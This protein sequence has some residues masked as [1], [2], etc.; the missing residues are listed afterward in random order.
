[1]K[2]KILPITA[3]AVISVLAGAPRDA[4]AHCQVPCGIYHDDVRFKLIAEHIDTI[5]KATLQIVELSK[6][7]AANQNQ[8]ARWVANKESHATKIQRIV[9]D[10]FVAQRVKLPASPG[11]KTYARKLALLHAIA[12]QSMKTKQGTDLK[13]VEALKLAVKEFEALYNAK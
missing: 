2:T 10:Y 13:A 4:F 9:S 3:L 8:I 5:E 11:D 7:A 1:M 12:V 6:D